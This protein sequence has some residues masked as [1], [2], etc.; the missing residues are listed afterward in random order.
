MRPR[1]RLGAYEALRCA[2]SRLLR[3]QNPNDITAPFWIFMPLSQVATAGS[4]PLRC[5]VARLGWR[6]A[7]SGHHPSRPAGPCSKRFTGDASSSAWARCG[8]AAEEVTAR[9]HREMRPP[10]KRF[11]LRRGYVSPE[12]QARGNRDFLPQARQEV[13][14]KPR[15]RWSGASVRSGVGLVRSGVG[16]VRSGGGSA[17]LRRGT[18]G[19]ATLDRRTVEWHRRSASTPRN[20]RVADVAG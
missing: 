5:R 7:P 4:A 17:A 13:A 1:D 16:L 19:W 10:S 12:G 6:P 9:P 3:T 18:A 14:G 2:L 15:A 11:E 8:Q 20:L